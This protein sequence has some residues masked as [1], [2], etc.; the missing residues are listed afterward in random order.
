[1]NASL[2]VFKQDNDL[3][4]FVFILNELKKET[5]SKVIEKY[6]KTIISLGKIK[7]RIFLSK[8][9]I[10]TEVEEYRKKLKIEY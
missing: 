10:E 6:I 4:K 3:D 9:Y 5:K 7:L 8:L 2:S 1:M